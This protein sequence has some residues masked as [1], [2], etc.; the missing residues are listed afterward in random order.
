M[1]TCSTSS[2]PECTRRCCRA[3]SRSASSWWGRATSGWGCSPSSASSP[4][5]SPSSAPVMGGAPMGIVESVAIGILVGLSSTLW[6]TSV[7]R[8]SRARRTSR[9]ASGWAGARPRRLSILSGALTRSSPHRRSSR[10]GSSSSVFG[11][12]LLVISAFSVLSALVYFPM[13]LMWLGPTAGCTEPSSWWRKVRG[14]DKVAAKSRRWRR[15]SRW[16]ATSRRRRRRRRP[17]RARRRVA[18]AWP[19]GC[20][21]GRH[22]N[23][24]WARSPPCSCRSTW[25]RP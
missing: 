20:G 25:R 8:S 22:R 4:S 12:F 7:W 1:D 21:G 2:C 24:R 10:R 19:G 16:R 23:G 15:A 9:G 6:C 11:R 5:S 13:L 14:G 3:A 17:R 18:T